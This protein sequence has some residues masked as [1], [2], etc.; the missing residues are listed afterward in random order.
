MKRNIFVMV[1]IIFAS[2]VFYKYGR[3]KLHVSKHISK[4]AT[5]THQSLPPTPKPTPAAIKTI[6]PV[7]S[8]EATPKQEKRPTPILPKLQKIDTSLLKSPLRDYAELKNKAL[9]AIPVKID[10]RKEV[11]RDPHLPSPKLIAAGKALGALKSF[12]LK[13]P[14]NPEI[15]KEAREFYEQC[16]AYTEYPN[17]IRTLCLYNRRV[18]AKNRGKKFD[19]TPYPEEIKKVIQKPGM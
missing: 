11:N 16:A 7:A 12:I 3:H 18:L 9:A 5:K 19:I 1:F 6:A 17:S 10:L 8:V 15:Q 14:D 4:Y 2:T 13:Y